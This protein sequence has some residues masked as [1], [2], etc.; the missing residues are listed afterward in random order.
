MEYFEEEEESEF[1][2]EDFVVLW[3]LGGIIVIV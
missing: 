2:S 1:I 3:L